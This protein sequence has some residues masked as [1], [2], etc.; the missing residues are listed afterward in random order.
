M[1]IIK[2]S[3]ETKPLFDHY[4]SY[5]TYRGCEF[6]FANSLFWCDYY[7]T[8]FT[9]LEDM[10]V[11]CRLE[12]G[13]PTSFTFPV[14]AHDP[15]PAFDRVVDYFEESNLPF[16]MYMVEPEMFEMIER[17]YPGQY[18]IEYDRDSADYM[19]RQE[20][21]A[22]LA[23]KKLHAKRNHI[24]RFLEHFPDYQYERI[25]G[26]N[27]QECLELERAWVRENN[28]DGDADKENE[29][30]IIAYALE[31]RKSLNMTGALIRVNGRVV[32]FTLGEPLTA[33]T[34]DV[35][36]E[37][38]YADIQGAYAMINR[39]FVR[40]ELSAFTY[41]NR[42]EDMGI[43]GLRKAKLSYHPESLVEKGIVT[44]TRTS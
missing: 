17:W 35:H 36:F 18:Q 42:E 19:Y 31:H 44:K 43:P 12:N 29:E 20:S 38:A 8:K 22:T 2:P 30:R 25:N 7:H 40:R 4:L 15:R 41:V 14:G 9:I 28:P 1:D 32:A 6:S 5:N 39:E 27:W 11:F 34:F 21:L 26:K 37:K 16:A 24:N 23:G 3:I 10:L 33:D 13:V